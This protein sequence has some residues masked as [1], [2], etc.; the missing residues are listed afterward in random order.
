MYMPKKIQKVSKLRFCLPLL[1]F[2]FCFSV[3]AKVL[4]DDASNHRKNTIRMVATNYAPWSYEEHGKYKGI[5]AEV[6]PK[7]ASLSELDRA[8]FSITNRAIPRLVEAA[9]TDEADIYF[10][11]SLFLP[12]SKDA[13]FFSVNNCDTTI[14]RTSF[15]GVSLLH[16]S[17][18][19]DDLMLLLHPGLSSN[20]QK[21]IV[22]EHNFETVSGPMSNMIKIMLAG[23]ADVVIGEASVIFWSARE[24]GVEKRLV[25]RDTYLEFDMRACV[26]NSLVEAHGADVLRRMSQASSKLAEDQS[27]RE[28]LSAITGETSFLQLGPKGH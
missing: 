10:M 26:S 28:A 7:F 12:D 2:I 25:V 14:L 19:K 15:I 1:G 20:L 17:N 24:L 18:K 21:Q 6:A 13:L 3:P 16:N 8:E 23:R 5:L 11:P 22:G 4:G 27:L 9:Y